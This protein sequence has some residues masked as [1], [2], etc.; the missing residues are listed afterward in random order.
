MDMTCDLKHYLKF[1]FVLADGESPI[2]S[3]LRREAVKQRQKRSRVIIESDSDDDAPISGFTKEDIQFSPS[4]LKPRSKRVRIIS[5]GSDTQT[6]QKNVGKDNS[7]QILN[8]GDNDEMTTET[9]SE[10]E[11]VEKKIPKKNKMLPGQKKLNFAPQTKNIS[12]K[13][14]TK[15]QLTREMVK[16]SKPAFAF[17]TDSH[18]ST[19]GVG[20]TTC[21]HMAC[22]NLG[23]KVIEMNASDVRSKKQLESQMQRSPDKHN[24]FSLIDYYLIL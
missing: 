19:N 21:A 3:S 11:F 17:R 13:K 2:H 5:D 20:K 7:E 6:P 1:N 9:D 14:A 4:P 18:I 15:D 12:T 24:C 23:F 10:D 8:E 16:N 22:Q